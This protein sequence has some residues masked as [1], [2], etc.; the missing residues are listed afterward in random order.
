MTGRVA[1]RRKLS[2]DCTPRAP[3][4]AICR[5]FLGWAGVAAGA[6]LLAACSTPTTQDSTTEST[7]TTSSPPIPPSPTPSPSAEPSRRQP[8]D[9]W[10]VGA[11]PLPRRPD[12]YGEVR[13]TPRE[14]RV[15]RLRTED[16]LEPPPNGQFHARV[17]PVTPAF[18]R[19]TD[20]AWR[21]GCPV[22]LRDLR[23]LRLSFW[24]FDGRPH[25]GQLV[26]AARVA[27]D[28]VSVFGNLY[29]AR[30]PL[31]EMRL[32]TQADLDAPPTGDGN[33]TAGYACRPTTGA[34]SWSAHAYGLAIDLNPFNNPY[35]SGDLVLPELAGSYLDRTWRRPGMIRRGGVVVE[36]FED[37]GWTWGGDFRS[38][39]DLHHFSATGR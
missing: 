35:R 32:V 23:S 17:D 33:N 5:Q 11:R 36:A 13:P 24:G 30:F 28:V 22:D 27:R 31:E 25:T 39:L 21:R 9:T 15:R 29:A 26:V 12:G 19:R 37:I 18:V 8:F 16:V 34:T 6:V 3:E 38:V 10:E 14:L 7:P 20:L 4:G 2:T 1:A